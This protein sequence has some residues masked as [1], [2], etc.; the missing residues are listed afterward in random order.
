MGLFGL[1][2]A[3]FGL[4]AVAAESISDSIS[5]GE[6]RA[7]AER[8]GSPTYLVNGYK[9]RSTKTG[10][11]CRYQ[12]GNHVWIVD[13]KTGRGIEDLT[14]KKIEENQIFEKEQ[15]KAEGCVFYRYT[16]YDTHHKKANVYNSDLIP[17][18]FKKE[19][20]Y[21]N[22]EAYDI[23]EEGDLEYA[24]SYEKIVFRVNVPFFK[25]GYKS[26]YKDGD[27]YKACVV[28]IHGKERHL[29]YKLDYYK[30][31][32]DRKIKGEE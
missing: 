21:F 6:N 11:D 17:G 4:G 20:K 12:Y 9:M 5:D 16:G 27:I 7:K 25:E 2:H 3:L 31:T 1:F 32:I 19:R 28:D 24:P 8:F 29:Y 14:Q 15:A 18:W 23:F 22:G 26:Y 10:R 30:D 13:S